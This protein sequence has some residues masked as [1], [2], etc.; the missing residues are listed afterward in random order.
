MC[1]IGHSSGH[2]AGIHSTQVTSWEAKRRLRTRIA[3]S[4]H[5][6]FCIMTRNH[7]DT[8]WGGAG[9][10]NRTLTMCLLVALVTRVNSGSLRLGCRLQ[11]RLVWKAGGV[12]VQQPISV[13]GH[14][15]SSNSIFSAS[16]VSVIFAPRGHSCWN[17]PDFSGLHILKN[18]IN[19]H[20]H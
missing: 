15:Y 2:S 3:D 11:S 19:P 6:Q 10:Q 14:N 20:Y 12:L 13:P 8:A 17:S 4:F 5:I 18:M 7:A 1:I 9:A 16:C